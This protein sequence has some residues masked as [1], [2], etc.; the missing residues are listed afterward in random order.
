MAFLI[1]NIMFSPI[2]AAEAK[3]VE[4]LMTPTQPTTTR[5]APQNRDG[6]WRRFGRRNKMNYGQGSPGGGDPSGN[7]DDDDGPPSWP[8][9][10]SVEENEN[11]LAWINEHTRKLKEQK[12]YKVEESYLKNPAL[13]KINESLIGKKGTGQGGNP[14]A[15]RDTASVKRKLQ[16]GVHPNDAGDRKTSN[17]GNGYYYIRKDDVRIIVKY[18]SK[19]G[20]SDIIGVGIRPER[21]DMR[22]LARII[23][24]DFDIKNKIDPSRY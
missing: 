24:R 9:C 3:D 8:V 22:K 2:S 10:E 19:T 18:D 5:P 17:L 15:R 4:G 11:D 12:E 21:K 16:D 23:N 6:F 13:K 20:N 7:P 14:K 1:V